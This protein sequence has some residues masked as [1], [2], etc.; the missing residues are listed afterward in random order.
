[1]I[2]PQCGM[3]T[4]GAFPITLPERITAMIFASVLNSLR[5]SWPACQAQHEGPHV[6]CHGRESA[7]AGRPVAATSCAR[8]RGAN[9]AASAE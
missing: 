8:V 4:I 7:L 6:G 9:A 5:K 3:L 1:M 2:P